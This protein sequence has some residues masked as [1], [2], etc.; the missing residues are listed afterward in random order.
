MVAVCL[1]LAL[2]PNTTKIFFIRSVSAS[3]YSTPNRALSGQPFDANWVGDIQSCLPNLSHFTK[4]TTHSHARDSQFLFL[5]PGFTVHNEAWD[6][7]EIRTHGP[8]QEPC[9]LRP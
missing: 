4:C 6:G 8:W 3:H 1:D 5:S 9:F 2:S 7:S